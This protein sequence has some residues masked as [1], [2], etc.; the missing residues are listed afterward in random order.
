M[1]HRPRYLSSAGAASSAYAAAALFVVGLARFVFP[2]AGFGDGTALGVVVA[3]APHLVLL[4]G[5]WPALRVPRWAAAAGL[6]WLVLDFGSDVL[7]SVGLS[8]AV[9]LGVRYTG[10]LFAALWI[11]R[12]A[13]QV[14]GGA[15][16][17]GALLATVLGVYTLVSP[18]VPPI[19]L[20]PSA[21]LLIAWCLL[22]GNRLRRADPNLLADRRDVRELSGR[23]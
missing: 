5:V 14:R 23:T 15:R 19:A 4:A 20:A 18:W 9:F 12:T 22:I 21:P 6:V 1:R 10:H 11:A 8:P 16:L 2:N 3:V 13:R 7:A 17:V